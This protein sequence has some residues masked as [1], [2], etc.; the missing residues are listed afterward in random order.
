MTQSQAIE[1]VLIICL[2]DDPFLPPARGAFGGSVNVMFNL[3]AFLLRQGR[4]VTFLS[5]TSDGTDP[6]VTEISERCQAWHVPLRKTDGG[7][8]AYY[9]FHE[10]VANITDFC[11]RRF[12]SDPPNA[13]VSY[14]WNSG[15][16]GCDLAAQWHI[17]HLHFILSL[18]RARRKAGDPPQKLSPRWTEAELRIFS[19]ADHVVAASTAEMEEVRALYPECDINDLTCIHLGV[20][21][22]VFSPR[23]RPLSDYIRWATDCFT[24]RSETL[25]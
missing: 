11:Q 19:E 9:E 1:S 8:V 18:S 25:P 7:S 16:V 22:R 20:D 5:T 23:P 2:T 17:R 10:H 24:E 12:G 4:S 14:N 15:L 21:S 13:I 6:M 3:G